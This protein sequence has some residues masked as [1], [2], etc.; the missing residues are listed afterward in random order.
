ML[1][2]TDIVILIPVLLFS[3]IAHECSH[4]YMA[5]RL[6]DPTAK[7]AGRLTF[8][9]LSHID[10]F[11]TILLPALL[12]LANSGVVFGGAKPVPY[13]PRYFKNFRRDSMLVAL[14]GPLSNAFLALICLVLLMGMQQLSSGGAPSSTFR[15]LGDVLAW[16]FRINVILGWFNMLPLPPLDGSKVVAYCLSPQLAQRYL[17]FERYGL[18]LLFLF[19]MIGGLDY[20]F[21][22]LFW[23]LSFVGL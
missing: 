22:P 11:M 5:L 4:G 14:A 1:T 3:V 2:T 21:K 19:L 17:M 13:D 7:R 12:I 16:G 15:A 23:A 20:W 10:P 8:N 18:V 9:P 6:G